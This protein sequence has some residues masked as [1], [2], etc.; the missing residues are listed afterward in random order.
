MIVAFV[1]HPDVIRSFL[2]KNE[3]A[4][5]DRLVAVVDAREGAPEATL[6][7][8]FSTQF[9]TGKGILELSY[10]NGSMIPQKS[11]VTEESA[12]FEEKLAVILGLY[13]PV[14]NLIGTSSL[15][16]L[17]WL[18]PRIDNEK[19]L[20]D[21]FS[22]RSIWYDHLSVP[23]AYQ[24]GVPPFTGIRPN[25]SR[26]SL[27]F[28]NFFDGNNFPAPLDKTG[29][30]SSTNQ[31]RT[32]NALILPVD[33]SGRMRPIVY[34]MAQIGAYH[35]G[36]YLTW[37]YPE[38]TQFVEVLLQ[39]LD[40]G[41]ELVFEIRHVKKLGKEWAPEVYRVADTSETLA[42][43][44]EELPSQLANESQKA[45]LSEEILSNQNLQ[46]ES[47]SDRYGIVRTRGLR[48]Q[49]PAMQQGILRHILA[50]TFK[51]V[52]GVSYQSTN[53]S[54]C[55]CPTGPAL[56]GNSIYRYSRPTQTYS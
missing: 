14:T 31:V 12:I 4:L 41:Q 16:Q 38:G 53:H 33:E 45:K 56:G 51:A 50:N 49:L 40:D 8:Y 1:D 35:G 20:A 29:G 25:S 43:L 17:A 18:L 19:L 55:Y 32:V 28:S 6:S 48:K 2:E 47:L 7:K 30:T 3:S 22:T 26:L 27:Q 44:V 13:R 39:R 42:R 34:R 54:S 23:L 52:A 36:Q 10:S 11:A 46:P 5:G 24:D 15:R 9:V 21:M 37:T